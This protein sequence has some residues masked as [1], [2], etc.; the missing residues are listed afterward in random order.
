MS[1]YLYGA[2]VQGIQE[3][4]FQTSKLREIAGA[5]EL[6]DNIC[7]EFFKEFVGKPFKAEN[8]LIG[9]AGNIKYIFEKEEDCK[10]I[11]RNFPKA[12]MEMADGITISQAVI[13]LDDEKNAIADLEKKLRIQRNRPISIRDN[14][15]W[16]VTETARKTGGAGVE[17]G[18]DGV[19]DIGQHQKN[20]A[21][22][23]ANRRLTKILTS[24]GKF[25]AN[26]F[27]F[28][29]SE[30]VKNESNQS[31]IAVIHADGNSLGNKLIRLGEMAKGETGSNTFRVFSQKL[32]EST[33]Q[34]TKEAFDKIVV[35]KMND[36]E[37]RKIPFRP[38]ILG[39]DDLTVIIRGDMALEFTNEFLKNFERI[40]KK[41]FYGFREEQGLSENLFDNGLTACAGIA[42]I[43]VNYPFHYGVTLAEN[44][45]Q[46][47]KKNAKNI[48]EKHVPSSLMVH[49]VHASFVEEYED[50]IEK[51]LR[52]KN[53]VFFNYGPYFTSS[54]NGFDTV[55]ALIKRIQVLNKKTAPKAGLRN[56]LTELK[57]NPE[58]AAQTLERIASLNRGFG[59]SLNLNNPFIHR[60]IKINAVE[61]DG[62][63]TPVFDAMALANI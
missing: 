17:Y 42:Y 62:K 54:Q 61:I 6:V 11:V 41:K 60:K 58:S 33:K 38:V 1:K 37:L 32:D 21:A 10:N 56:W 39:G 20:N 8:L 30:I 3:F 50:I 2:A 43:K 15:S 13:K 5:S 63:F 47:A 45:C 36:E 49:K 18:K 29:I 23:K 46:E 4:I 59:I 44:L 40:T 9:A 22:D 14:V 19:I 26:S 55:D 31:W 34:A 53:N 51:E 57:S 7:N 27:P 24:T 52:A 12:V 28:D 25:E 48:D 35:K 16:M